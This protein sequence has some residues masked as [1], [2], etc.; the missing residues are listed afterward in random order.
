MLAENDKR[1]GFRESSFD[2]GF[3]PKEKL[4]NRLFTYNYIRLLCEKNLS[5]KSVS[6][7]LGTTQNVT[8]RWRRG[9]IPSPRLMQKLCNFLGCDYGEF[10]KR[11]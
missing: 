10:F 8:A 5:N 7:A 2:Q 9:H 3:T 6:E 4:Y 11:W 1:R